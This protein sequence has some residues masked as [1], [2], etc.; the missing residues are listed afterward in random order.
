[1]ALAATTP[2][3][4]CYALTDS[5]FQLW[6][7]LKTS[8]PVNFHTP[9]WPGV[10]R[11]LGSQL[12][13]RAR[14]DFLHQWSGSPL[15]GLW[16]TRAA[17]FVD[18]LKRARAIDTTGVSGPAASKENATILSRIGS[19]RLIVADEHLSKKLDESPQN[20]LSSSALASEMYVLLPDLQACKRDWQ[21][22]L[23]SPGFF[24]CL[25]LMRLNPLREQ[26]AE[27][28]KVALYSL[29]SDSS[30][31]QMIKW[32]RLSS[33]KQLAEP[34]FKKPRLGLSE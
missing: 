10:N 3:A 27:A 19:D 31:A 17:A 14:A 22:E 12:W 21:Y 33:A 11:G 24:S 15:S 26:R 5:P 9:L 8:L 1:Y 25:L 16:H 34:V 6:H 28:G 30:G 13:T 2:A 4:D 32:D 23:G 29:C 7:H 18:S 20:Q